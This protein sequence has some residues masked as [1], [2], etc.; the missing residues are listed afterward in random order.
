MQSRISI[1]YQRRQYRDEREEND[2]GR[3]TLR[4][5]AILEDL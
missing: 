5:G 3:D 1:T 4:D 2:D